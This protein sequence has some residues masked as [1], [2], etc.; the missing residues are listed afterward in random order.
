MA[1]TWKSNANRMC[2]DKFK[3]KKYHN[4]KVTGIDQSGMIGASNG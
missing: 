2:V 1:N 4:L 3:A